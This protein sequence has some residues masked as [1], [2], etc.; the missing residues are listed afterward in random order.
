M[1][2]H[3]EVLRWR[4]EEDG[5]TACSAHCGSNTSRCGEAHFLPSKQGA[6]LS[7]CPARL[8]IVVNLLQIRVHGADLSQYLSPQDD[9]DG[10]YFDTFGLPPATVSVTP[11]VR[12]MQDTE[13][14]DM[15]KIWPATDS[16]AKEATVRSAKSAI[17]QCDAKL[18]LLLDIACRGDRFTCAALPLLTLLDG[19]DSTIS[20]HLRRLIAS[21]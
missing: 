9:A 7:R 16:A 11:L 10:V 13:E 8:L 20:T 12:V 5:V 6:L 3:V 17:S 15:D 4:H 2:S 19:K 18:S 21:K 14:F 1:G